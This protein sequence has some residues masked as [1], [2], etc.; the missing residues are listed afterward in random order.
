MPKIYQREEE[1]QHSTSASLKMFLISLRI[2]FFAQE[3]IFLRLKSFSAIRNFH[4]CKRTL[5]ILSSQ[6]FTWLLGQNRKR[7]T[8]IP[9]GVFMQRHRGTVLFYLRN[10]L[11]YFTQFNKYFFKVRIII[12]TVDIWHFITKD[13]NVNFLRFSYGSMVIIL[14]TNIPQKYKMSSESFYKMKII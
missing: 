7:Y 14:V 5:C 3:K 11:K 8:V 4:Q 2:Y 10:L 13:V 1:I 6:H 9:C 12:N